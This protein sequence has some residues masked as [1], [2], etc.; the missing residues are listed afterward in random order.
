MRLLILGHTAFLGRALLDAACERG[1]Q[2]TVLG[3]TAPGYARPS[4][5]ATNVEGTG[6]A[7]DGGVEFIDGTADDILIRL[8]GRDFDA[9]VDLSA[10]LSMTTLRTAL[11]LAGHVNFYILVSSTSVYRD[12]AT[13][14]IDEAYPVSVMP[15]GVEERLTDFST[16]GARLALCEQRVAEAL[17][18]R[19]FICRPGLLT[20]PYDC[21]DRVPRVLR[22]IAEGGEMF[23]T[24]DAD[25]PIQLLDVRDLANFLLD[26]AAAAVPGVVN[27]VGHP[28][29]AKDLLRAMADAIDAHGTSFAF[30]GDD[31]LARAGLQPMA[32]LPLW[33]PQR[34]YPGFFRVSA[35]R[36][37]RL[38]LQPRPIADTIS[39]TFAHM[40]HLDAAG[41]QLHLPPNSRPASIPLNRSVEAKILSDLRRPAPAPAPA[42][43]SVQ[44]AA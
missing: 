27:A 35:A 9:V 10:G 19:T 17:P 34:G 16:Y 33:V 6:A 41:I 14:D 36:A 11:T 29:P 21:T 12:F 3:R 24:G 2:T 18:D 7:R 13:A 15:P 8:A 4:F 28:A 43:R 40:Q 5:A 26:R 23:A 42:P 22:R 32:Q 20:G 38:G 30:P 44:T 39:A 31:A 25:Q 1:H 37:R